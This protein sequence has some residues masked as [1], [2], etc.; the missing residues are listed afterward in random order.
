MSKVNHYQEIASEF[1][2]RHMSSFYERPAERFAEMIEEGEKILYVIANLATYSEKA[3]KAKRHEILF[4]I[5]SK[6]IFI[7]NN[8]GKINETFSLKDVTS[9]KREGAPKFSFEVAFGNHIYR[10]DH[11]VKEK[12]EAIA[13]FLSEKHEIDADLSAENSQQNTLKGRASRNV[14][15]M[16]TVISKT[17]FINISR[18]T[19]NKVIFKDDNNR[20]IICTDVSNIQYAGIVEGD[21]G[22]LTYRPRRFTTENV[23][24]LVSFSPQ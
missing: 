24:E 4:V 19:E 8:K 20:R 7:G 22:L 13:T 6:R 14:T 5:T 11:V 18:M 15:G 16:A 23:H 21:K 12:I 9:V 10:V 2:G 1:E 17:Q 3:K